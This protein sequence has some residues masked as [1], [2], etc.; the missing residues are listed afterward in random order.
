LTAIDGEFVVYR[1]RRAPNGALAE[2]WPIDRRERYLLRTDVALPISRDRSVLPEAGT[3]A[4]RVFDMVATVVPTVGSKD[5]VSKWRGWEIYGDLPQSPEW[6][7]L[8]YDVC[9]EVGTSGLTNCAYEYGERHLVDDF[10]QC[11]NEHH[12]FRAVED[13]DK[14]REV[15]DLRVAEH[16]PFAVLAIYARTSQLN[17]LDSA[18]D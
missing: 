1:G 11:I 10:V 14:F 6:Q 9:D 12:L 17:V 8:G 5:A 2:I 13:A 16:A 7:L 3:H 18:T 15:C 4:A